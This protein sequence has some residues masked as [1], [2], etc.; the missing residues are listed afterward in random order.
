MYP[1]GLASYAFG[2]RPARLPQVPLAYAL[3][4]V[5]LNMRAPETPMF[6]AEAGSDM[7]GLVSSWYL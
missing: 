3:R 7:I 4:S 5:C 6:D 2:G 1:D